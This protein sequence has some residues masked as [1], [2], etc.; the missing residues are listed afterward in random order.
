MSEGDAAWIDRHGVVDLRLHLNDFRCTAAAIR[1]AD[2]VVTVDTSVAHIAGALA[3]PTIVMLRYGADWRWH[4]DAR[5]SRWYP[6]VQ[7]V[8][9]ES[10]NDWADV[11][12][13]VEVLVDQEPFRQPARG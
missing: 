4:D 7:I 3:M 13:R 11:V 5:I 6:T 10:P 1:A 9:Q 2:G 12:K 8:R